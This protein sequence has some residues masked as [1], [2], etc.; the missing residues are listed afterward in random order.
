VARSRSKIR[1]ER[2][3]PWAMLLVGAA[4]FIIQVVGVVPQYP[5][6][7]WVCAGLMAGA[8][9]EISRDSGPS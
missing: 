1:I 7:L 8:T 6:A 9:V 2:V 4:G 3:R 5:S